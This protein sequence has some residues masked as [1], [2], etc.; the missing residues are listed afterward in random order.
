MMACM[1][2]EHSIVY[3]YQRRR[4]FSIN[5]MKS[6]FR[7]IN[8]LTKQ[9]STLI[10]WTILGLERPMH[11]AI[12]TKHRRGLDYRSKSVSVFL[13]RLPNDFSR[14]LPRNCFT[15]RLSIVVKREII[16]TISFP[17]IRM[18]ILDLEIF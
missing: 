18:E 13:D 8:V 15:F 5:S 12:F 6:S 2:E 16:E 1:L 17:C 7:V 11:K 14:F 4:R 9:L 3:I 10:A